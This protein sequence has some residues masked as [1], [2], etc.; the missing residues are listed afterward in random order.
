MESGTIGTTP[1]KRDIP[2][3]ISHDVLKLVALN[4]NIKQVGVHGN[5]STNQAK[6][7][8]T[9]AALDTAH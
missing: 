8:I 4:V 1:S 9:T 2:P 7:T 6:V 5:M 3:K